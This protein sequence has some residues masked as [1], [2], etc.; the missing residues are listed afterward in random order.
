MTVGRYPGRRAVHV[1]S[2]PNI[3]LFDRNATPDPQ[4]GGDDEF[5]HGWLWARFGPK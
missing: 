3:S 4:I 5:A 2:T 1:I